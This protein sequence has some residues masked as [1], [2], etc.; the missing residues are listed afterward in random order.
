MAIQL[1]ILVKIEAG[2]IPK[3]KE[4]ELDQALNMIVLLILGGN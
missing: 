4:I 1:T 2:S 3:F